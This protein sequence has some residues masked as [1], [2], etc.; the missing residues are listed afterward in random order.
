MIMA[1]QLTSGAAAVNLQG[2]NYIF[3]NVA[4]GCKLTYIPKRPGATNG[5]K[6]TKG[7]GSVIRVVPNNG[8]SS[9]PWYRLEMGPHNCLTSAW[10]NG[11][12]YNAFGAPYVCDNVRAYSTLEPTKQWWLLNPVSRPTGNAH[13]GDGQ[14]LLDAQ[15]Q[16]KA[17]RAK[18]IKEQKNAFSHSKFVK[19]ALKSELVKR[20]KTVHSGTFYLIPSDHLV[21]QGTKAL[22]AN[23]I[24]M[25]NAPQGLIEYWARGNTGQQWKVTPA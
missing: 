12:G 21:D 14:V 7:P 15:Q 11:K 8:G 19:R 17:L 4:K 6:C 18:K 9:K 1:E 23:S 3:T 25:K 16:S 20:G 13:A 24:Q 10:D 2:G 5:L 22:S